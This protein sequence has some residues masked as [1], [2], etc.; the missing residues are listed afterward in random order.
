MKS[1]LQL[2]LRTAGCGVSKLN[3]PYPMTRLR[4]ASAGRRAF[5]PWIKSPTRRS[6]I[7][8]GAMQGLQATAKKKIF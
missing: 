1:H 7:G 3:W 2:N 8:G 5:H 6:R 4:R